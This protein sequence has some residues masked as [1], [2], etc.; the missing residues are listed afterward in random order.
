MSDTAW[1]TWLQ[2]TIGHIADKVSRKKLKAE[3]DSLHNAVLSISLLFRDI[4]VF[5]F[6]RLQAGTV[7]VYQ[8]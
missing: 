3:Y 4:L 2:A 1:V 7:N 6:L 8:Y 5:W